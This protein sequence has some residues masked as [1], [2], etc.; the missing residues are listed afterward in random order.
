MLPHHYKFNDASVIES[1][2]ANLKNILP[3]FNQE[4][5]SVHKKYVMN[6]GYWANLEIFWSWF[7]KLKYGGWDADEKALHKIVLQTAKIHYP[8]MDSTKVAEEVKIVLSSFLFARGHMTRL[9]IR[10][11]KRFVGFLTSLQDALK[12]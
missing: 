7:K 3:G 5:S 1:V 2:R 12:E 11:V 8:Q 10:Y 9:E 4:L 6:H